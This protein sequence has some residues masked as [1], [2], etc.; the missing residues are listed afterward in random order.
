MEKVAD[1]ITKLD[2]NGEKIVG[3]VVDLVDWSEDDEYT[4]NVGHDLETIDQ[5]D[6]YTQKK[7]YFKLDQKE[8]GDVSINLLVP[9]YEID[10]YQ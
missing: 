8:N 7:D 10:A 6:I 1:F 9:P 3:K 5:Q 2:D 4:V